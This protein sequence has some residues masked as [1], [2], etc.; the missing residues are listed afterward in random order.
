MTLPDPGRERNGARLPVA[1]MPAPAS[2]RPHPPRATAATGVHTRLARG[3]NITAAC[4][5]TPWRGRAGPA[6]VGAPVGAAGERTSAWTTRTPT[7]GRSPD[8]P[9]QASATPDMLSAPAFAGFAGQTILGPLTAGSSVNG[10]LV[11]APDLN[12]GFFSGD[13]IFDIWDGGDRVYGLNWQGGDIL[14]TLTPIGG[15]DPDLFLYTPDSLDESSIYD[16]SGG[17]DTVSLLNAAPGTYYIVI[18]T[19]FGAEGDFHLDVAPVPAPGAAALLGAGMLFS[20]RR[21]R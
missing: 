20:R 1:V 15:G 18:D 5:A 2:G 11:G 7:I 21:R 10:T 3:V 19:T 12:D 6:T 9:G 16:A 8:A 13:H 4:R 17:I 14:I